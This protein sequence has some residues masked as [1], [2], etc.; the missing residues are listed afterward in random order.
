MHLVAD[1]LQTL[2]IRG[3]GHWVAELSPAEL[4]TR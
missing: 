3:C 2:M 1:I 4:M